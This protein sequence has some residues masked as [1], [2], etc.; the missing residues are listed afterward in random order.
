[1]A[2]T[3]QPDAKQSKSEF[4]KL[5]EKEEAQKPIGEGNLVKGK[6]LQI[7]NDFVMVDI[8]FKS[9]GQVPISEFKNH[10]GKLSIVAG[11]EIEVLLEN[12]EDDHG[13]IRLSKERADALK[14]WD[15]LVKIQEEGGTVEGV[16]LS[17]VK[18]GL[19]VDVG[20]KAFLPGS[21]VDVRPVRNLDRYV[22][23][24]FHFKIIKLNKRRG[25]IVL[26]RKEAMGGEGGAA[27]TNAFEEMKVGQ[28]M[29]GTV[30]NVTDYG[31]F[32][33]LGGIDG[34]LHVT[35]MS[36]GRVNHPSDMFKVGDVIRVMVLRLD[37]ET[38]RISLGL[39]QLQEDPW[40][41]V[42]GKF[43]VGS[44]IKGKVVSLTDYGA[45][46]ELSPGIEGLVHVSEISWNKK[47]KHP[48]QE[49]NVGMEVEAIVLDCD[50]ENRRIAL[51]MK[52]L[53]PNPWDVLDKEYPVGSKVKGTI[54]NI[55]D[56]GLFVD[57][58]VGIDGLVH[59][60]DISWVQN[61]GAPQ[62]VFKRG[63]TIET[64]V[65]HIDREN[66]RFSLSRKQLLPNPWKTISQEYPVGTEVKGKVIAVLASGA[67][68]QVDEN[69]E[70]FLL[71]KGS[72]SEI[73]VGDSPKGEVIAA[74]EESRKFHLKIKE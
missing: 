27:G 26:S 23:K 2:V 61:F 39:K 17:K 32:V 57:C 8:G 11:D 53:K 3:I 31:A 21:Q 5:L 15:S 42:A 34:L 25:N 45:F 73:R 66:E 71:K 65:A 24:R 43:P 70:G 28:V 54:R 22:G 56:F 68:V 9:E 30:K 35:D 64:V 69:I 58:G 37:G 59:I 67:I 16:V 13:M 41:Q 12:L 20:V 63:E 36:W 51:G 74:D 18:G 6:V 14:A 49:L 60:S 52:Q 4:A 72:P 38:N 29:E 55:T 19:F 33:D 44:K 48:S 62:E 46:V 10:D 1:M 47:M 40:T 7:T 50:L